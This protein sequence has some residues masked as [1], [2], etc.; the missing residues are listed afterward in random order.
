MTVL[1]KLFLIFSLIGLLTACG[2]PPNTD[3][4]EETLPSSPVSPTLSPISDQSIEEE[5]NLTFTLQAT[6]PNNLEVAYS[7]DNPPTGSSLDPQ[8]GVFSWTP[9][10]NQSGTYSLV[11]R[12]LNN[13]GVDST[14]VVIVVSDKTTSPP[15]PPPAQTIISFSQDTFTEGEV[16]DKLFRITFTPEKTIRDIQLT[17]FN[18][19]FTVI[20]NMGGEG[21]DIRVLN[22][23]SKI[24]FSDSFQGTNFYTEL[25]GAVQEGGSYNID[26]DITYDDSTTDS[27]SIPITITSSS[28]PIFRYDII[29]SME[30]G[31]LSINR[32]KIYNQINTAKATLESKITPILSGYKEQEIICSS[33]VV[34]DFVL[35]HESCMLNYIS[36]N[37]ETVLG[38]KTITT[39]SGSIGGIAFG[40]RKGALISKSLF[41]HTMVHELGH[42]FGLTHTFETYSAA[43][44]HHSDS[45]WSVYHLY[46]SVR[47][48][49]RVV[50]SFDT[51]TFDD[52]YGDGINDTPLDPFGSVHV[53]SVNGG[54]GFYTS[55]NSNYEGTEQMLYLQNQPVSALFVDS[56]YMC[57]QLYNVGSGS[58]Y[59]DCGSHTSMFDDTVISN[60]MS[61]WYKIPGQERFTQGQVDKMLSVIDLYPAIK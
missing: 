58:Y 32:G 49:M 45:N 40:T 4:G 53:S 56:E 46:N 38:F 57:K 33:Q 7:L 31:S 42:N 30:G 51:A 60:V 3:E 10:I 22:K 35:S 26:F 29:N 27:V 21:I 59:F 37:S 23:D 6:S 50:F 28:L 54:G 25:K 18:S 12:A 36:S 14:T 48:F 13:G 19:A 8:T 41:N 9:D 55:F 34:V 16:M 17:N 47:R 24:E 15:P 11:F 39:S 20:D 43:N 44:D 2:G 52:E 5:S 1:K 61:Y